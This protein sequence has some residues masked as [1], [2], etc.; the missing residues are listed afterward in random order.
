MNSTDEKKNI[1]NKIVNL[2]NNSEISSIKQTVTQIINTINDPYSSAKDITD[3][4]EV[5]PPLTA[6]LLKLA[7]S[8]FYGYPKT[9]N[10]IQEAV[11]CIGF[12]AV[13]ELAL[14][15]KVCELFESED[16]VNGYTRISLWE[17][18]VAV[19]LCSKLISRR[20][21]RKRGENIYVIGLLHDIGII[22]IDQ[23]LH[24]DFKNILRKSR[25]EKN[26]LVNIENAILGYDHT[27]IGRAIAEDWDFPDEMV[28]VIAN[29]HNP[30]N[31]LDEYSE[32]SSITFVSNYIVQ[33]NCIGYRDTPYENKILFQKFLMKLKIN[34]RAVNFIIKEV[35]KEINKMKKAGWF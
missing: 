6:K 11:V 22:V 14:S 24:Y 23:F 34:E 2:V 20:E 19:A 7:N 29:H 13:K 18:S 10:E 30:G 28:N 9:I 21:F 5:D 16:S 27:D 12:E 4:I 26:N 32:I 3:I 8:A 35:K 1:I 17:H 33:N 25:S 31:A 15:Q